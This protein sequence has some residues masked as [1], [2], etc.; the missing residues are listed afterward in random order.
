LGRSSVDIIKSG[1]FKISALEV[2]TA[3]LGHPNI[4]DCTVVGVDDLTWGQK[5]SNFLLIRFI[6]V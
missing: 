6:I 5:V 3:I 1:G 2:E 4:V